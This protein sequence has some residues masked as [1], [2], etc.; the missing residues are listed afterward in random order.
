MIE[1]IGHAGDVSERVV[2]KGDSMVQWVGNA[3][4]QREGGLVSVGRSNGAARS[5]QPSN[6]RQVTESVI[7]KGGLAAEWVGL[8][9]NLVGAGLSRIC[10]RLLL[11]LTYRIGICDH[12]AT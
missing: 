8:T 7:G 2:A 9:Q 5:G 4:Q 11:R 10:N 1:R 3:G 6:T 12:R